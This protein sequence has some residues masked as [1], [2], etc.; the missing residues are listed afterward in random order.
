M[1]KIR[2]FKS[3]KGKTYSLVDVVFCTSESLLDLVDV[4][5][6][7]RQDDGQALVFVHH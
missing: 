3:L 7:H 2:P 4:G 5:K 1:T 6:A